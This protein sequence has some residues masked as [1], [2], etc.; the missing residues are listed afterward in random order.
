MKKKK[1]YIIAI[2]VLVVGLGIGYSILQANLQIN[3]TTKIGANQWKIHFKDIVVNPDSVSIGTG[4][5]A[6]TI[7]PTNDCKVDYVITLS[8]PGDFYEFTVKVANDGTIDGM[9]D[10]ISSKLNG[11]EI[12]TLPAYLDYSVT[13]SDDVEIEEGQELK[14]S[15]FETIKVRVEFK[16]NIESS[17]LPTD[18]VNLSLT[19]ELG[20]VQADGTEVAVQH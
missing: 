9:I 4:D 6:A 16:T 14:K 5:T 11:T 8:T 19:Y 10:S 2:L 3:G 12:T 1:Y 13:Y 18:P 15:T 7:D 20:Y 17:Q